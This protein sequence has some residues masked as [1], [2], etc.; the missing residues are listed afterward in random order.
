MSEMIVERVSL[1]EIVIGIGSVVI[2]AEIKA[3]EK[4]M[5]TRS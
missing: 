5:G 4:S 3:G 2:A 1:V